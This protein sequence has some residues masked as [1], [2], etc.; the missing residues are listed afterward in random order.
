MVAVPGAA[1]QPKA[2]G[3][4]PAARNDRGAAPDAAVPAAPAPPCCAAHLV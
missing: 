3:R 4:R 1:G 2:T